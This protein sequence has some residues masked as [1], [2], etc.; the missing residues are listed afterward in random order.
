M[1]SPKDVFSSHCQTKSR[2]NLID[3]DYIDKL[4]D[5]DKLWLSRFTDNYYSASFDLNP[6]FVK[7]QELIPLIEKKISKLTSETG[8]K[9]WTDKL[10]TVKGN[11]RKFYQVSNN[12]DKQFDIDLRILKKVDIF[13]KTEAGKYTTSKYYKYTQNNVIDPVRDSDRKEC[14][15]RSNTQSDCIMGRY[16]SVSIDDFEFDGECLSPEDILLSKEY[17][18]EQEMI[19]SLD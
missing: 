16:S 17:E 12:Q 2:K 4:S 5:A 18:M 15:D 9:K 8:I 11:A 6:A 14:N 19:N 13:Y 1:R 10:N 3:F 7:T